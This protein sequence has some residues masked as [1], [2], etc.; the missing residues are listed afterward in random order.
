ML[1]RVSLLLEVGISLASN[2]RERT[3]APGMLVLVLMLLE[4][5]IS[6]ASNGRE[7]TA[8]TGTLIAP[9]IYTLRIC[10]VLEPLM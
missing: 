8:V 1:G 9:R 3:G 7:R 2:G 10:D 5:V 6:L 4:V